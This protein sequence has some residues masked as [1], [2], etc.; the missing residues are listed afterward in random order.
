MVNRPIGV[1]LISILQVIVGI[2]VI[3][4]GIIWI[5]ISIGFIAED[6]IPGGNVFGTAAGVVGVAILITGL[7]IYLLGKGL[8]NLSRIVWL[9]EEILYGLSTIGFL[10]TSVDLSSSGEVLLI[11]VSPSIIS[12]II[13]VYLFLVRDAFY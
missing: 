4:S 3:L 10:L 12:V 2:L 6:S 1:T 8:W 11:D 7:I 13:F 9:L 5:F